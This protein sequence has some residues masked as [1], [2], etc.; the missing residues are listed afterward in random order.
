MTSSIVHKRISLNGYLTPLNRPTC[1]I[2]WEKGQICPLLRTTL[3]G[4]QEVCAIAEGK[5]YRDNGGDGYL[6][7]DPACPVWSKST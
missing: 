7:P 5:L 2:N 3:F 6:L 4:T 1:A